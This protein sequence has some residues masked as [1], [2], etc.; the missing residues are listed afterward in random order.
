MEPHTNYWKWSTK[1]LIDYMH[2]PDRDEG[3]VDYFHLED[4]L[5]HKYAEENTRNTKRLVCATW[6]LVIITGFLVMVTIIS[7]WPTIRCL[8]G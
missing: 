1:E 3:S 7:Q 4:I 2:S 5:H 8:F 6:G